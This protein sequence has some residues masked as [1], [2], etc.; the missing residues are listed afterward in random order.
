[1]VLPYYG[2]YITWDESRSSSKSSRVL[3]AQHI[4]R[5]YNKE[6]DEMSKEALLLEEDG[7]FYVEEHD[8]HTG[9]FERPEF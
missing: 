4:Y 3:D 7:I 5:A 6:A 1:L 9:N 2:D 8:G